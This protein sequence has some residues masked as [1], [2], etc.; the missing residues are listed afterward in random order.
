M[1]ILLC[2]VVLVMLVGAE[3][4]S[5]AEGYPFTTSLYWSVTTATTVGYG[6]VTPHNPVGKLIASLVMLTTIPMLATT[7]AAGLGGGRRRRSPE[8]PRHAPRVP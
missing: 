2:S 4:F 3:L 7:F 1:V 6:D 5:L 8:D